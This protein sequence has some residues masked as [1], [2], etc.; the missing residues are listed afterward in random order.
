MAPYISDSF[1]SGHRTLVDGLGH[2]QKSPCAVSCRIEAGNRGFH[3]IIDPDIPLVIELCPHLPGNL[4]APDTSQSH[5]KSVDQK[6]RCIILE[7]CGG[8][9]CSAPDPGNGALDHRIW[10]LRRK[11]TGFAVCQDRNLTGRMGEDLGF[12]QGK[13]TVAE[14]AFDLFGAEK[15][16]NEIGRASC[17]ERV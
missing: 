2:L 7:S 9:Q 6:L 5:K 14:D 1:Q 16:A 8:D 11:L 4:T 15:V 10:T 13:I 17:R 12:V 3:L